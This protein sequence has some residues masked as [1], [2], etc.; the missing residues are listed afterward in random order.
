MLAVD[1]ERLLSPLQR[2]GRSEGPGIIFQTLEVEALLERRCGGTDRISEA[3][4][5]WDAA[6]DLK[7]KIQLFT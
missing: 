5:S 4:Q 1:V 6:Q 3:L 7:E 2:P